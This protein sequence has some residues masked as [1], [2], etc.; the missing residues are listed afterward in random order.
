MNRIVI[1]PTSYVIWGSRAKSHSMGSLA[2]VGVSLLGLTLI[3]SGI[4]FSFLFGKGKKKPDFGTDRA[5]PGPEA[6]TP[7]SATVLEVGDSTNTN[8]GE[9]RTTLRLQVD[10]PFGP[11]Y[12]TLT[13]W[14]IQP[15]HAADVQAGKKL[16]IK[17][18]QKN[19]QV[20]YPD[21]SLDWAFQ[22]DP[23]EIR[24]DKFYGL[25][26]SIDKNTA[27]HMLRGMP[28]VARIVEVGS[29]YNMK[30]WGTMV[31]L[32]L[33]ITPPSGSPYRI[34]SQWEV[35]PTYVDQMKVGNTFDIKIDVQN[36][37]VIFP[38]APWALQTYLEEFT[39]ED[40]DN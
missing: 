38:V 12:E 10:P 27:E 25:S 19:P 5:Q 28:A 7:A 2:R 31:A 20:I 14:H 33:E 26:R 32:R 1:Y 30:N 24:A 9:L 17:I 37:K 8:S 15:A 35:Q 40:M 13:L 11:S 23:H 21:G 36:P 39:D 6:A 4:R 18:D 22:R 16:D 34:V 29:S 3:L